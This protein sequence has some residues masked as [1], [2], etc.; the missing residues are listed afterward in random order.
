MRN[1]SVTTREEFIADLNA[2]C[3]GPDQFEKFDSAFRHSL[4]IPKAAL[5]KE[6]AKIKKARA[7]KRARKS[8]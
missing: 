5:L 4:T 7:K 2:R 8:A 6:E 1:H 3:E